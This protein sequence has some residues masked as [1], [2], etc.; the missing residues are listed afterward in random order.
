MNKTNPGKPGFLFFFSKWDNKSQI[1]SYILGKQLYQKI[2]KTALS[3]NK[4][5]NTH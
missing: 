1:Q 2:L 4:Q 3:L 5:K